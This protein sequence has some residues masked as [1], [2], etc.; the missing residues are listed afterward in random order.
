MPLPVSSKPSTTTYERALVHAVCI[1]DERLR[2]AA[3]PIDD[4]IGRGAG[5]GG[6]NVLA[7][8]VSADK[9]EVACLCRVV[10]FGE[11]LPR[12]AA[13]QPVIGVGAAHR[14]DKKSS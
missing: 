7:V 2:R 9:K 6:T 3:P 4:S 8:E 14:I 13:A 1:A 5:N 12:G 11:R 10:R